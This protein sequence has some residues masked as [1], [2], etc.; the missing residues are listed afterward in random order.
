[1]AGAPAKSEIDRAPVRHVT[2]YERL[3]DCVHC[4]L[5]LEACPTYILTRAEM[6]SPRGRV[7][8]M[9]ALAEGRLDLDSDTVR[10]FDLCLGC[11]GCETA[12]PSGVQYG[13]LIEGTRAFVEKN[14]RRGFA[15]RMRRAMIGAIFPYPR[16]LRALLAPVRFADRAG[17]RGLLEIFVSRTM[18]DWLAL[19]P[20]EAEDSPAHPPVL[21]KEESAA[22]PVVAVH[23]GCVAR[24]LAP[25]ENYNIERILTAW[26]YCVVRLDD[27]PCC[28]ALDLHSGNRKRALRF[29]RR[30]VE[31]I[32]RS[33]ASAIVSA[34]SGCS[35]AIADYHH[36]LAD[37]RELAADAKEVS[38]RLRDL[39]ALLLDGSTPRLREMRCTVTYHDACHLAHG[40][41]VRE[42]PRKLLRQIPGVR[43]VEMAESDLCCGSAGSYNLTEPAMARDLARRKG[44]NIV[45]TKADYA[46]LANPGCEF[47]IAAELKRRGSNTRVIH[48]GDFL[49]MALATE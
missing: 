11:R 45:R 36:L 14:H 32:K 10:H 8:L 16:R 22:R 37:D 41:G 5:C 24:V 7:H 19:L 47:Q 42:G 30:N 17:L 23:H 3:F 15:D 40:L 48:L 6:D 43:I 29:V 35:T 2:E 26:G 27:A 21:P 4:G 34:A 39:S 9:K 18:R 33:G 46:V 49:A 31:I 13:R 25:S 44:A 12:C 28:G 20:A 38:A 1:M